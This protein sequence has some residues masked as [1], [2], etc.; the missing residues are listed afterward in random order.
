M[1][2]DLLPLVDSGRLDLYVIWIHLAE[3]LVLPKDRSLIPYRNGGRY[4]H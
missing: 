4:V 2:D 1:Y 3:G